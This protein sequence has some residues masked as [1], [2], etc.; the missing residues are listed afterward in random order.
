MW[1]PPP[2]A[3]AT[4]RI[5]AIVLNF[6]FIK[7]KKHVGGRIVVAAGPAATKIA[8]GAGA[9]RGA[10]AAPV[11]SCAPG[12]SFLFDHRATPRRHP[13]AN[14]FRAL[15]DLALLHVALAAP[16]LADGLR[17]MLHAP[18]AI[19]IEAEILELEGSYLEDTATIGNILKGWDGYFH[20]GPQQRGGPRVVKVKNSDRI[21]SNSSATAPLKVSGCT[22][23]CAVAC[24]RIRVSP[25]N[26]WAR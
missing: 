3:V 18:L 17:C 14:V 12:L 23:A 5:P 21:F 13:A 22:A 9:A 2:A 7:I 15:H 25:D 6:L 11:L 19:Q 24:C 10:P 20:S 1:A 4:F 8:A 16:Q 26:C